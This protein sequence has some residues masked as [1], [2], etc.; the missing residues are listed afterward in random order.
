MRWYFYQVPTSDQKFLVSHIKGFYDSD[1]DDRVTIWLLGVPRTVFGLGF[2]PFGR[3][4][5]N[6]FFAA[7]ISM[8][9]DCIM[10]VRPYSGRR[11]GFICL[12]SRDIY[13]WL[14]KLMSPIIVFMGLGKRWS[15][16][17]MTF[18]TVP[19]LLLKLYWEP[20]TFFRNF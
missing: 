17:R 7:I 5:R 4:E 18:I 15:H 6:C 1:T 20:I 16:W 19:L 13:T 9:S 11:D 3:W 12:Y 10:Q 2:F 8:F 14:C